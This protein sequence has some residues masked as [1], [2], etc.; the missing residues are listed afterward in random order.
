MILYIYFFDNYLL[1]GNIFIDLDEGWTG[2]KH[3]G[4][5]PVYQRD[6]LCCIHAGGKD[7]CQNSRE[8]VVMGRGTENEQG[9]K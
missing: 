1:F 5:K 7:W 4:R 2:E 3:A 6:F 9:Y 8:K